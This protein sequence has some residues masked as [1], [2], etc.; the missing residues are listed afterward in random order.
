MA[1]LCKDCA[2]SLFFDPQTQ[3]LICKIC[4]HSFAPEEIENPDRELL[5]ESGKLR[6]AHIYI[7]NHCGSEIALNDSES[8]S[9]CLFC[10]NPAIVLTG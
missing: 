5:E 3:K 10:G 8:S 2:G 6:D 7:C 9:F 1:L 4:G